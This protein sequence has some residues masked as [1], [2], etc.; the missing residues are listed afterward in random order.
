MIFFMSSEFFSREVYKYSYSPYRFTHSRIVT[1]DVQSYMYIYNL[2]ELPLVP[3]PFA[4]WEFS[5]TF[6]M[7]TG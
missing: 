3:Y 5:P 6:Y 7:Y 2:T 1:A 4:V